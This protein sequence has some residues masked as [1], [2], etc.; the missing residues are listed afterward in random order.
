MCYDSR[1]AEPFKASFIRNISSSP[2]DYL[3]V[4][5]FTELA[6]SLKLKVCYEGV[7]TF[8]D[9]QSVLKFNPDYIQGL[10]FA[11]PVPADEFEEAYLCKTVEL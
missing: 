4:R 8:E 10:Y 11:K 9:L 1:E 6:H 5:Q 7:E 3:V 2:Y